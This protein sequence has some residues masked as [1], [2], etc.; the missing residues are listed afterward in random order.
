[1][2]S[3]QAWS[4]RASFRIGSKATEKPCLKKPH[5][6]LKQKKMTLTEQ[7][8]IELSIAHI[9]TLCYILV[10]HTVIAAIVMVQVIAFSFILRSM[11][12][13]L[14]TYIVFEVTL[15]KKEGFHYKCIKDKRYNKNVL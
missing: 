1:M 10:C 6:N 5:T 13:L 7:K 12:A 4:T 3:R 15:Q 14:A 9:K 8:N 11:F 2:S